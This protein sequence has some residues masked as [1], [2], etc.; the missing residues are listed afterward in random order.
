MDKESIKN[1]RN[2][3]EHCINEYKIIT[4]TIDE[5]IEDFGYEDAVDD[6]RDL[7]DEMFRYYNRILK[8]LDNANSCDE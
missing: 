2:I 1:I 7:V 5:T 4:E 3:C 8:Y 6:L